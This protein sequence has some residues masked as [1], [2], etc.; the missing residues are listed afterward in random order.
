MRPSPLF[1]LLVLAL[2]LAACSVEEPQ[3]VPEPVY[4]RI[5]GVKDITSRT[6][7]ITF[8]LNFPVKDSI[9]MYIMD[10]KLLW[11]YGALYTTDTTQHK[12]LWSNTID[13]IP[14]TSGSYTIKL[15]DLAPSTRYFARS[16]VLTTKKPYQMGLWNES[17]ETIEFETLPE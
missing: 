10:N 8:M 11:K 6:A 13:Q 9:G 15:S 12:R 4:T 7:S 17:E 1:F 5:T 3:Y 16:W 14:D 2:F